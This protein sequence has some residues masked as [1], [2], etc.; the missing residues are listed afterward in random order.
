ME[1]NMNNYM[2]NARM[3]EM[4]TL[5]DRYQREDDHAA[6]IMREVF[7]AV[8]AAERMDTDSFLIAAVQAMSLDF[9]TGDRSGCRRAIRFVEHLMLNPFTCTIVQEPGYGEN[10][11]KYKVFNQKAM[12]ALEEMSYDLN[13]EWGKQLTEIFYVMLDKKPTH[14]VACKF[15][16]QLRDLYN[17]IVKKL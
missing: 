3:N 7:V 14:E 16:G 5:M 1:N 17:K 9:Y 11:F 12:T 13:A 8:G 15:A 10:V 4:K 6:K 2:S